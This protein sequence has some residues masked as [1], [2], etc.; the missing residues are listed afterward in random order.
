MRFIVF[1]FLLMLVT[2]I[3]AFCMQELSIDLSY[4][5]YSGD[6]YAS[7]T[8]TFPPGTVADNN[9]VKVVA[10]QTNEE[11]ATKITILEYWLDGSIMSAEIRFAANSARKRTYSVIFGSDVKRTKNFSNAAVLPTVSF[12]VVGSPK[13]AENMNLDVGQINVRV[14]R[15][16]NVRYWWHLLPIAGLITLTVIRYKK[17]KNPEHEN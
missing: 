6:F 10:K 15:S 1:F 9:H 4:P 13:D 3:P 12:S 14:D 5:S 17:R 11:V 2:P 8:V 16:P 7:G